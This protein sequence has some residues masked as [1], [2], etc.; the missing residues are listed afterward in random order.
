MR[1]KSIFLLLPMI[2][3]LLLWGCS[4]DSVSPDN[5]EERPTI[6]EQIDEASPGDTVLIAPGVYTALHEYT[7]FIGR[8]IQVACVMKPGVVVRG[9][10]GDPADV[11]IDAQGIGWGFWFHE[12]GG[13]TGLAALTVRN[14]LWAV[15]GYDASPWI[16]NCILE[17]NG[18]T[19]TYP[20]SSG[21]G[22]YFDRSSSVITDCVFRDNESAS[23]GGATF[24]TSSSVRLERCVFTGN[25]STGS[26]GGLVV[27]NDSEVTLIDCSMIQNSA[28]VRGGGV[29][30]YGLSI[31]MTGGSI[32][33]N[34]A[35]VQGGGCDIFNAVLGARFENVVIVDNVAPKGAQGN[36]WGDSG[37]VT[38]VCCDTDPEGW[39]GNV[40]FANDGC[41][42]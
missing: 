6:Q 27:G 22:M 30:S 7:D 5:E 18:D 26:G 11:I 13:S 10:T 36:V 23:G 15:S 19:Q 16:D 39:S 1:E 3:V 33:G 14:A 4:D 25:H 9:A 2:A 28:D 24:S 35:G 37:E 21:A 8:T 41:G 29:Y 42:D 12:T 40:T 32:T 20:A 38:L 34:T 31:V 17:S